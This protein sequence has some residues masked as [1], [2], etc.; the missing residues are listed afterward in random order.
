VDVIILERWSPSQI[1]AVA[2]VEAAF[3][4]ALVSR[5]EIS[6]DQAAEA[7]GIDPEQRKRLETF[8]ALSTPAIRAAIAGALDVRDCALREFLRMM[9]PAANKAA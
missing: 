2:S 4:C 1:R 9:P 8:A 5:G 6:L 3:F 7:I